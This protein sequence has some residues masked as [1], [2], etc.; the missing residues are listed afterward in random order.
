MLEPTKGRMFHMF[1]CECG[2]KTW[3]GEKG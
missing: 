3:I 2:D 1:E